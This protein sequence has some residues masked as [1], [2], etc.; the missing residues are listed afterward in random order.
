MS[1]DK[2]QTHR[3]A[4]K[5]GKESKQRFHNWLDSNCLKAVSHEE[6]RKITSKIKKNIGNIIEG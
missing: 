5:I 6:A 2:L 4:E 1:E 3:S